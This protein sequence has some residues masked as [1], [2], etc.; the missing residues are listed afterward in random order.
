M[1]IEGQIMVTS[2]KWVLTEKRQKGTFE[3]DGNI[4]YLDQ[5]GHFIEV[6]IHKNVSSCEFKM[7]AFY[8]LSVGMH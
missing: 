6:F 8:V 2:T 4:L 1:V 5:S 7:C 3:V